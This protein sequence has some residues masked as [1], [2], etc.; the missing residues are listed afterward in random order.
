MSIKLLNSLSVLLIQIRENEDV[1]KEELESF[2]RFSQIPINNFSVVDVFKEPNFTIDVLK[3]IDAVFIGGASEASVLETE[4]YPFVNSIIQN[5]KDCLKLELPVF[6]SCFG[7]QAAV[8]ALD[9]EIKRDTENFEMGTVELQTT[10]HARLDP[11]FRDKPQTFYAVSVHQE[12]ATE[13]PKGC[14]LLAYT[15]QCIH[16]FKV[17]GKPFWAFQFHPELDTITLT[18]RLRAYQKKYTKDTEQF[19]GII[20]NL[21][22]T[23]ESNSL[24]KSF[25]KSILSKK[26][27]L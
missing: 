21:Q 1:A 27:K 12:K 26:E 16:A 15:E 23:K 2:A 6:A 8:L 3:G 9:G 4:R 18:E 20:K 14:E 22:P 13:L 17:T 25:A 19:E 24:V 5:I 7:F 10:E 11:I